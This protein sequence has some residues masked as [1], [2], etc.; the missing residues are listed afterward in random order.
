[1]TGS[2]LLAQVKAWNEPFSQARSFRALV[3][4]LPFTKRKRGLEGTCAH[5]RRPAPG[6]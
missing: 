2:F 3:P 5:G 4:L 6:Q 1:M